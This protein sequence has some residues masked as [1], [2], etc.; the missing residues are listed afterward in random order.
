MG[1]QVVDRR[2]EI[3]K[4][5]AALV[6]RI[7]KLY[8]EERLSGWKIAELLNAER[9]PTQA[10]RRG[11]ADRNPR[12]KEKNHWD[13]TRILSILKN[14]TY[15]G[16]RYVGKRG[17]GEII[18]QQVPTIIP[19]D[20]WEFA[21]QLRSSNW[22]YA[23]R[24]AKRNYLLRGLMFCGECGRRYVGISTNSGKNRY[25]RCGKQGCPNRK[26]PVQLIED[27]VW[28]DIKDFLHDPGPVLK[29]LEHQMAAT[30]DGD[31]EQELSTVTEALSKLNEERQRI[32][33]RIRKGLIAGEEGDAQLIAT[34]QERDTLTARKA[35]LEARA[36][37]LEGERVRQSAAE[38]L[39]MRLQ[40]RSEAADDETKRQ[41]IETLVK[42]ITVEKGSSDGLRLQITYRFDNPKQ[43][44]IADITSS[45]AVL[46]GAPG[47]EGTCRRPSG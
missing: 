43:H 32:L 1:Y 8:T 18:T 13:H 47:Q 44:L 40:D 3:D 29:Q 14:E 26:V 11:F 7:Y 20:T 9:I 12:I 39:L 45:S 35:S 34:S 37:E 4:K 21:Q 46:G 36:T 42:D 31:A 5:E 33:Y 2:L 6:R 23:P 38:D 15:A 25:Y 19:R 27:T 30:I 28:N 17:K 10:T 41:V 24:N 22:V 16:L